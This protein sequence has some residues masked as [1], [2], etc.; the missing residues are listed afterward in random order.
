[1][2]KPC[3]NNCTCL[4][5]NSSFICLCPPSKFTGIYCEIKSSSLTIKQTVKRSFGYIAIIAIVAV[6]GII[7]LMDVLKYIFK[8]DSIDK[9]RKHRPVIM[10]FIYV[11]KP[12]V[13]EL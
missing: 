12:K 3:L 9:Q 6:R 1:M 2:S 4:N 8:I 10:R 7:V 11:D 5:T 13:E